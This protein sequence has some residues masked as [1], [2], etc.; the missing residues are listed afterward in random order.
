MEQ[1]TKGKI[2]LAGILNLIGAGIC[3]LLLV[4]IF[5]AFYGGAIQ[6]EGGDSGEG[7]GFAVSAVLLL[8]LFMLSFVPSCLIDLVWQTVFGII[9]LKR[10]N[11]EQPDAPPKWTIVLSLIFKIISVPCFLFCALVVFSLLRHGAFLLGVALAA[12]T[13]LL[14]I[15]LFVLYGFEVRARRTD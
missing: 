12:I 9:L 14:L 2:K 11:A 3:L 4:G 15:Y 5:A 1:T 7:L 13:V 6:F 8:V 10:A